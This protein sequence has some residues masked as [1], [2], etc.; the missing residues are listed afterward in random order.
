MRILVLADI[1]PGA[2]GGAEI[3]ASLLAKAWA[4]NGNQVIVA[5]CRNADAHAGN[6]TTVRIRVPARPRPLRAAGYLVTTAWLLWRRRAD[7]DLIYCRFLKEQA[8]AASLAKFAFRLDQP[9]VACPASSSAEGDVGR[10]VNS[11]VMTALWPLLR[12][13]L[14]A[15]NALSNR[16]GY[17][18]ESLGL[19][20]IRLSRIPNGV[21]IPLHHE[22]LYDPG[23]PFRILYVGRLTEEKGLDVLIE[24]AGM[25][26]NMHRRFELRLA[27]G[28]PLLTRLDAMIAGRALGDRVRL[29]GPLPPGEIPQ[30]L[31]DADLF[32]L[33]SR[34]EGMPGALLEAIA[35]GLPAIATRISGSEEI[36]DDRIGWLVPPDD[37]AALADAISR[38]LD[39]GHET[40]RAMGRRAREKA[41]S[42]YNIRTVAGQYQA[43]FAELLSD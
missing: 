1:P 31:H 7:Y 13:E 34:Q 38:A 40:L 28:G 10:I 25:L 20:T 26:A 16:I 17:E 11:R 37:P 19:D 35:H 27:G 12:R 9:L 14:G 41:I 18:L 30:E 42:E 36:I 32:V 29:L 21:E 24:A 2:I 23:R 39:C 6:L 43:L 4:A 3:Q 33:P 8:L 5:G 15:I 22:R